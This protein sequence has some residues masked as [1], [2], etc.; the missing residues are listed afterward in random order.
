MT[1][2]VYA[3]IYMCVQLKFRTEASL[4]WFYCHS[5]RSANTSFEKTASFKQFSASILFKVSDNP[6]IHAR[7]SSNTFGAFLVIGSARTHINTFSLQ[8]NADTLLAEKNKFSHF[9]LLSW[10]IYHIYMPV[11][12]EKRERGTCKEEGEENCFLINQDMLIS[13]SVFTLKIVLWFT[14]WHLGLQLRM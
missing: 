3:A 10:Q 11:Q 12:I 1:T 2:S 13:T 4:E 5:S 9:N 6:L 14:N 8:N 7:F